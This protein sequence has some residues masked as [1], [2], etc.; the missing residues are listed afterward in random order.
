[1]LTLQRRH[2]S[3]S[4]TKVCISTSL[5]VSAAIL[6]SGYYKL[7]PS[8][9]SLSALT[10]ACRASALLV[11]CSCAGSRRTSEHL[12]RYLQ[13]LSIDIAK[14]AGLGYDLTQYAGGAL[15][16]LPVSSQNI[17]RDNMLTLPS[18]CQER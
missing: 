18:T 13:T 12:R 8:A 16:S 17:K 3:S 14:R 4:S 5:T 1:M 10:A 6:M 2:L 7:P 9:R 11:F 15:L